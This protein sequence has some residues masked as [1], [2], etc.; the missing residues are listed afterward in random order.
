MYMKKTLFVISCSTTHT[1]YTHLRKSSIKPNA[2][3]LCSASA[4]WNYDMKS[5]EGPRNWGRSFKKCDVV[6]N[7]D[8]S[9]II[10]KREESFYGYELT[11]RLNFI[12]PQ[13]LGKFTVE[14]DGQRRKCTV[15]HSS[16][17]YCTNMTS[18][19]QSDGISTLLFLREVLTE[20]SCKVGVN[21][22]L[23]IAT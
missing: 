2:V 5:I 19:R 11:K 22:L 3:A 23:Y 7:E 12:S 21:S 15:L 20:P 9:P 10:L 18:E 14:N 4:G 6:H 1:K 16:V 17:L 13:Q 8:Q